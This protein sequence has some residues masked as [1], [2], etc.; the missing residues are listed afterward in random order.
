MGIWQHT[1][2]MKRVMV[3]QRTFSRNGICVIVV[4]V[5]GNI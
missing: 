4:D 3:V 1:R 2:K 5:V